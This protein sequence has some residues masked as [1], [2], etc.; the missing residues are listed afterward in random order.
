M[1]K[2]TNHLLGLILMSTLLLLGVNSHAQSL[3]MTWKDASGTETKASVRTVLSEVEGR[4]L[5][6][7][8][9]ES[10]TPNA[11]AAGFMDAEASEETPMT[12]LPVIPV[13]AK[14]D[15]KFLMLWHKAA[16]VKIENEDGS[17][18]TFSY[19]LAPAKSVLQISPT[20]RKSQFKVK[21]VGT[22]Q[23]SFPAMIVCKI[24]DG[25][26]E[27]MTF[28]TLE[29]AEWFGSQAFENAGKGERWKSFI[30]KDIATLGVWEVSW[31]DP[32]SKTVGKILI[33][34]T[35]KK[36][37]IPPK[38]AL[39]F[40]AGV[41]YLSGKA[42]KNPKEADI[43]GIQVP[44]SVQYQKDG[45]WWFLGSGYDFY[46]FSTSS[47]ASGSNS[48]SNLGAWGGAEYKSGSFAVRGSLGYTSRAL[49]VPD[50][51]VTSTF[52]APRLGADLHYSTGASLMG[53]EIIM[54]QT[55]S[56]GKYEEMTATLFYQT[57]MLFSR[58][59]RIQ[60]INT[61]MKASTNT[62]EVEAN[63][64]SLGLGIQF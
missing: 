6:F 57:K 5:M 42:T 39:T 22:D 24:K 1:L 18:Y 58:E 16:K 4:Q 28:S 3:A 44:L 63:W 51:S 12:D 53:L 33:P 46:V 13:K 43:G 23:S 45:A 49:T 27:E 19:E 29:E 62:M 37:P 50:I 30:Y 59:T 38:P 40:M 36:I 56:E 48:L 20:C 26:V 61:S 7:L 55:S 47:S 52:E 35:N 64:I 25:V 60:L 21:T 14:G 41:Q 2:T 32:N 17:F 54:A 8:A 10:P 15:K 31:G 11:K 9:F 34:K